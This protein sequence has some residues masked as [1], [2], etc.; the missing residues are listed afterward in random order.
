MRTVRARLT[1][2]SAFGTPPLGDT[3]FGQ[4]CWAIRNRLG[5]RRLTELLG[6]YTQGSPFLVVSDL[7]PA[8]YLPRP[9]LPNWLMP[10]PDG[11]DRKQAKK[12]RWLQIDAFGEPVRQW[13]H[14]CVLSEELP[15]G[16]YKAY[17]QPHNSINRRTGTT[18]DSFTPY[19]M[20]Q[21]WFGKAEKHQ[22]RKVVV[23]GQMDLYCVVD[24]NRLTLDELQQAVT[25]VGTLGFGRDA[26][27]GLGRFTVGTFD[28]TSL[29]AQPEA[30]AWLT[31]APC[32]PQSGQ[33]R[34][35]RCF[36]QV[37]TRFGRH[38]DLAVHRDNPFKT[39]ALLAE[40]GAVLTPARFEPRRW[41][42]QG[43]GGDGT[44][45]K[46]LPATVHQAYAPVV[47]IRLE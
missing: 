16:W 8:G 41:I 3:L 2:Q 44:L 24:D 26:S 39:P 9:A 43:L 27:I 1:P 45:S 47:A 10:S 14:F 34:A 22:R 6:G 38:G 35:D 15:G 4:L 25:D 29:P 36:Y 37:F 46:G 11:L 21:L 32:A 28:D 33:W 23:M 18:D 17:P 20:E 13:L 30:N 42:G 5:E 19:T 12:R 40:S 7:L 31:L